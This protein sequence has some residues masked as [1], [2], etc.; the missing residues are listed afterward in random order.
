ME[1]VQ[2][3]KALNVK[4]RRSINGNCSLDERENDE[5]VKQKN[6]LDKYECCSYCYGVLCVFT[7]S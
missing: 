1:Y 7:Q 3:F 5:R 4:W 6:K 2:S